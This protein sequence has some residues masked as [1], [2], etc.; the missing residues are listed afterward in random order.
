MEMVGENEM[1]TS[2]M[3][4]YMK[5][6]YLLSDGANKVTLILVARA[7]GVNR[8]DVSRMTRT[9]AIMYSFGIILWDI[10]SYRRARS[11]WPNSYQTI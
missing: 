2:G 10:I 6:I 5:Q 7:L 8:A 3:K 11:T 1:L 4:L 9:L